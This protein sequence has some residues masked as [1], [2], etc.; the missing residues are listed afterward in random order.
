MCVALLVPFLSKADV[1][2][3]WN[4]KSDLPEGICAATN[5]QGVEVDVPST[6]EGIVMHVDATNGKLF[7]IDRNNAQFNQGTILRIPVTTAKDTV[8]VSGYPGYYAY[9]IG[10]VEATEAETVHRATAAE[11]AQGYVEV[12]STGNNSY[13]YGVKVVQVSM[14]QEKLLYSADFSTWTKVSAA[15]KVTQVEQSTKYSH[16]NFTFDIYDTEINPAGVNSKFN[17][18]EALGWL[19]AAKKEDP[20]ILTST[21]ASISKVRYVHAATGGSRGWKMWAKGDGDEDWVVI[22]DS[23]AAADGNINSKGEKNATGWCEVNAEVNRTNVQL[24]WTNIK[25]TEN[26]YMFELDLYG[27]VDMSKTPA[28][29]SFKVN[30]T[31]YDAA[32]IFAEQA[33][34]TNA[35]TIEI[36]KAQAMISSENPLTD[37]EVDNG[38]ITSTVYTLAE[39]GKTATATIVVEANGDKATY[40]ATFVFK[41]DFTVSYVNVDG[42][43]IGTQ[44]VEKDAAISEF[45]Y[46][47]KDV[48]VAD[49]KKFRGWFVAAKGGRKYTEAEVITSDLNVYAVTTDIETESATAR[50]SYNLKDLYFEADDHEAFNPEGT[51]AFHDAIHGWVFNNGD[52]LNV[53]VGGH[54]YILLDLCTYSKSGAKIAISN[55]AGEELAT[56]SATV[57]TDGGSNT[58][59]Y[60]GEAGVLTLSFDNTTYVHGFT[61]VNDAKKSIVA[62]DNGYYVVEAGNAD[63]FLKTLEIANAK[64][65]KDARTY[66]FLPD[67][68]YDLGETCLT[69]VSGSN[70]SI[71]GQSMD[72]TIIMNTAPEESINTTATLLVTGSN[73]YFQDLTLKNALNYFDSSTAGR[74]VCLQDKG[75][76]T[77]CKNVKLLSY[78]DTYYSNAASQF[79]FETSEIHGVVDYICG[80]G[81]V[82]F[83]KCKLVNESRSLTPKS[84]SVTIAAPYTDESNKFGYVF[85]SCTIENLAKEFNFGRA[86]GGVARL[87]YLNTTINQPSEVT[88][89][90]FTAA[91]MN[92]AADKFV[93]YNSVDSLGNVVSPASNVVKFTKDKTTNEMETILTAEQA[94]EYSLDK[95]FTDWTPATLAA[96]VAPATVSNADGVISWDA[97][98][99]AKAYAVVVD[100]VVAAIV[101][102][103]T[104][105]V[106][107]KAETIEV[108]AANEMGGFG[109]AVKA[110]ATTGVDNVIAA[111]V[112]STQYYNLQGIRVADNA[113]G[114]VVRVQTLS[115]GK[116]VVTKTVLK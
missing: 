52:K 21:F 25:S 8:T 11:A 109:E 64:S 56:I 54:A 71:I 4:F 14:I 112:V 82:Y 51:C 49:G 93:E 3:E 87:A 61:I 70:I 57:S 9:S 105:T 31:K 102:G 27:L 69:K 91:G 98:E 84:G 22:S 24:K 35:A 108:R 44:I 23:Y 7:C 32:D 86:W 113:K 53:L 17:N 30:G 2:A 92:V 50:Y 110:Q 111:D 94:S 28:L 73:I 65:S 77:I 68:T 74:A 46:G 59:E 19:M 90:R 58:Y 76:R 42:S 43:V 80:G 20:Y 45:K 97:V 116:Q 40:V 55:A 39:D 79:Y 29:G 100:G 66:I 88:S 72:N 48:T 104:Y 15:T 114:V 85:E 37:V 41:P 33:D 67:G 103:T 107:D 63:K 38:E 101:E 47:E 83:N 62:S 34:G 10:G 99:G 5:Y 18:G 13:I 95:V 106:A 115:N 16:E 36:P 78:Q 1:T 12:V 75:S 6:V 60:D 81:D 26:A 89:T 96:Q